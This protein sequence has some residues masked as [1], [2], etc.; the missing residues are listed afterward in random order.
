[1]PSRDEFKADS[2]P[3]RRMAQALMVKSDA[4][5]TISQQN[6]P[7]YTCQPKV[8]IIHYEQ[9]FLLSRISNT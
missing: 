9:Q 3:Q 5:A 2:Q 8:R 7:S 1:M 6:L 4:P